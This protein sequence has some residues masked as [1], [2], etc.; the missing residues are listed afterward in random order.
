MG[1]TPYERTMQAKLVENMGIEEYHAQKNVLSKSMLVDLLPPSCP[2]KFKHLY[3]DGGKTKQTKSLRIGNASH[4]LALEPKKFDEQYF[5]MSKDTVR[6]PKSGKYKEILGQAEG[7]IVLSKKE[8]TQ[9]IGMA[10]AIRRNKTAL[11]LLDSPGLIESSIFWEEGG[12]KYR[13]RPDFM[14][15]DGLIID[16]KTAASVRQKAFERSADDKYY[17]LSVA[18]TCRGY[19]ALYGKEPQNYIFLCVEQDEPHLIEAYDS[20]RPFDA[21]GTSYLDVGNALLDKAVAIYKACNDNNHWPGYNEKPITAL[22]LP[23]HRRKFLETGIL[24]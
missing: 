5:V 8:H 24:E 23:A 18:L 7:R 19:K 2:A 15:N 20:F 14:R 6:N 3:I 1:H 22:G 13:C 12:I 17:A 16:L 10:D 9:V 11:A 21:F 4:V